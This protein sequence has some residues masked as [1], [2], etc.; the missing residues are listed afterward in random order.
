[1]SQSP[2]TCALDRQVSRR[3][4]LR[5][6]GA[7]LAGAGALGLAGCGS[8]GTTGSASSASSGSASASSSSASGQPKRGGS[9]QVAVGDASVSEN[10]DPQRP[11]NQNNAIYVPLAWETLI[12][13][14]AAYGL[15]PAL[16][17]SWSSDPSLRRWTFKLRPGVTFHDG[18]PLTAED[19]VWSIRRLFE[20]SL[21]SPMY[22][23]I[24]AVL[25]PKHVKAVDDHTVVATLTN[26]DAFFPLMFA[27]TGTEIVKAGQN[28]FPLSKAYGTGPFRFESFQAGQGWSVVRNDNYWQ[29]GLPYLDEIRGVSIP[30]PTGLVEAVTSGQSNLSTSISFS[31]VPIVRASGNAK[32]LDVPAYFDSYIVMNARHK[33]FDDVRVRQAVKLADNRRLVLQSAYQNQ[34]VLTSDTPAPET[35]P[36]YPP[37][38]GVRPQEITTARELLRQAGYPNGLELTLYTS[39]LLGGMVDMAVAFA[40]SVAAAGIHVNVKQHPA[41]TYFEQ[42]WLVEAFY[43]SW[44]YRRHPAIRVP[45]T[46]ASY[47]AWHETQIPHTRVDAL[48]AAAQATPDP[49][50]QK[51]RLQNLLLWIANNDGYASA[52]FENMVLAASRNLEGV[53]FPQAKGPSLVGAW[54]A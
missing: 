53:T 50:L 30:D 51:T 44:V 13:M 25:E 41:A 12:L 1:M 52:A 5:A 6:A 28:S 37:S 32:V 46:L 7:A 2:S 39:D 33:P 11:W 18:S 17:T 48:L 16:A 43:T 4:V 24:A 26:P 21:A 47:S 31:Q 36:F 38:L 54:L 49:A 9:I 15:H 42:I 35:D 10:L 23:P 3:E 14:D 45:T 27:T 22:G 19:V 29:P 40:Q 34:G 20:P 8:G